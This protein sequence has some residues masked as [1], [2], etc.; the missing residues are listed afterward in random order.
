MIFKIFVVVVTLAT[1]AFTAYVTLVPP[2]ADE[3]KL[4]HTPLR[5]FMY[6]APLVINVV[7]WL[8][9]AVGIAVGAHIVFK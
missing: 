5:G 6:D 4:R 7:L 9:I 1:L 2:F 3:S 8:H